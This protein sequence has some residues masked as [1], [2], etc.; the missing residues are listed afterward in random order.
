MP[1]ANTFGNLTQNAQF[2]KHDPAKHSKRQ[3]SEKEGLKLKYTVPQFSTWVIRLE[4]SHV[5]P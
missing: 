1:K 5:N 4:K 3:Q 2:E